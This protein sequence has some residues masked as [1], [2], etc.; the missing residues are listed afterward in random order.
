MFLNKYRIFNRI[1]QQIITRMAS[2]GST[3]Y[4][5]EGAAELSVS[6]DKVFYNPVQEFN[7]D[8]SIAVLT[9]FAK[10]YK[11][12]T[13]KKTLQ[14][15]RRCE[16]IFQDAIF[17]PET[18]VHILEALAATG[19]RSIRYAKEIPNVTK[20]VANDMSEEAVETMK[21]NVER[22]MVKDIIETSQ[23][24]A[25]ILMM[26]NKH[27]KRFAAV[28]LDPYGCPSG[29]LD[30][31]VQCV[32]DGGLLLVTATD[33][34]VL[35]GNSPETC[36]SKYGSISVK[37]KCCH[38]MALRILLQ[39]I[40]SHA[41]RYG[42]YIVPLLSISVDFYVRVFVKI[43]NGAEICK[44]T[45][46]KLSM[47]K[48]CVGCDAITF[49]PMGTL[50]PH[51]TEKNPDKLKTCLPPIPSISDHC[52]H[53]NQTLRLC[54]PIWSHPIHD[55]A[56]VSRVLVHVE[57][58]PMLF[59]TSKRMAGVLSVIREEL[60]DVP[61]YY[62]M[63]RL[64]GAVH[65]ETMPMLTM[66][67]AILNAGYRVSYSHASKLSIKTDAPAQFV[68]DVVRTWAK[69]HPA[70]ASKLESDAVARHILSR[71]ITST[72]ELSP[73]AD[74]NPASRRDAR[75]RY[76]HNPAPNWGPGTRATLKT[77]FEIGPSLKARRKQNKKKQKRDH[78]PMSEDGGR[79]KTDTK[80][81]ES[82]SDS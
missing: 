1:T 34:A 40:E 53:C 72:V 74:A 67:S 10:E 42:R 3:A 18:E 33:M 63:Q 73:R 9:I 39:C 22:N 17:V 14:K 79:K 12:E 45:I 59:N 51:P 35:A 56:F 28:D 13:Q 54:G 52:E 24:D 11:E 43:Y 15:A 77:G 81:S 48:H 2:D 26:K 61:L 37:A 19:L 25:C 62:V 46:S 38:E 69:E 20:V 57:E 29:F 27:P 23:E 36:Y 75:L 76:Q 47:V 60:H 65:L 50:K 4:I 55:E 41:N 21:Y 49:L 44:Q 68:W 78:S 82:E 70:K 16:K 6:S 5:R 71:D 7:R 64:F 32:Q 80:T 31:A 66:R 58:N 30:S 8:L